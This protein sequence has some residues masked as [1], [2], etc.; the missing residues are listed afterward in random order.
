MSTSTTPDPVIRQLGRAS[1][2]VPLSHWLT[3]MGD[4]AERVA[5]LV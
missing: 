2:Y 4:R 1:R 3:A 5:A